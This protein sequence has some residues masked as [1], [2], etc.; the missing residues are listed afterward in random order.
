MKEEKRLEFKNAVIQ[1]VE[2]SEAITRI[3]LGKRGLW[4]HLEPYL[5]ESIDKYKQVAD[6]YP[7]IAD[8]SVRRILW[9]LRDNPR[10]L[11][12]SCYCKWQNQHIF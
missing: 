9:A 3:E 5:Y 8:H 11:W 6:K 1:L 4:W 2:D 10:R 7:D 12:L